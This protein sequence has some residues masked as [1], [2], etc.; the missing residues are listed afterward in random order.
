MFSPSNKKLTNDFFY[1]TRDYIEN[2]PIEYL[3]KLDLH[4]SLYSYLKVSQSNI[5]GIN[6]FAQDYLAPELRDGY[7]AHMV[8]KKFPEN[9]VTKDLEYLKNKLRKRQ[10]H[11]TSQVSITAPSDGF[12]DLVKIRGIEEGMTI[13]AI[14]G[15]IERTE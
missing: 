7:R 12:D 11:F 8:D 10:V 15:T 6:G 3:D 9:A 13:V 4:D 2:L 5:I 1:N 14:K